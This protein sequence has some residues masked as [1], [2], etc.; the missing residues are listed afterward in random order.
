M[1]L[2]KTLR[3]VF[4]VLILAALLQPVAAQVTPADSILND[5][6][7]RPERVLVAAHRSAHLVSPEN[8]LAAIRDAI[9]IG[10]D[11]IEIDVRKTKDGVYVLSH[12]EKIDRIT[13]SKGEVSS[14][15]F[16]QLKEIP[17][18]QNGQPTNE[19]I[20]TFESALRAAKDKI[21]I[22]IDF[23]LDSTED[24]I[25]VCN[26]IR[27]TG[28]QKQV[29]FFVYDYPY[30]STVDSIDNSIAVMPRAYNKEDVLDILKNYKVPVIHVDPGFY[31]DTLM[32][33]IRSHNVRVWL[34]ALGKFDELEKIQKNSGYDSL[35]IMKTVN[36]IQTDYPA[37]LL[38]YLQERGLHR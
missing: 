31:N 28:M 1:K 5:F 10:A 25:N 23:K 6:Y 33:Q 3:L 7:H 13:A 21:M 29:L 35:L 14:Y 37:N 4:P 19:R 22:D 11:I 8:S 12:D 36:V 24:A 26:L 17:L 30:T 18:L 16:D 2:N 20:P 38:K 34:N 15:T 27:E 9:A 32:G